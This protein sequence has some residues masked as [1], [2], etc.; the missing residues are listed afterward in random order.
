M[1][2]GQQEKG[3]IVQTDHIAWPD[4]AL[5]S[6]NGNNDGP[7][8]EG[9][10]SRTCLSNSQ[11]RRGRPKKRIVHARGRGKWL[12]DSSLNFMIPTEYVCRIKTPGYA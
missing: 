5:C 11:R 7:Y 3:D 6:G 1:Q 2:E 4:E 9:N 8:I 12:F 10:P